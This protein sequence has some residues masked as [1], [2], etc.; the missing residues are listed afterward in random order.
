MPTR[1]HDELVEPYEDGDPPVEVA[2]QLDTLSDE[3]DQLG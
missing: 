3:I 1:Q 2:D